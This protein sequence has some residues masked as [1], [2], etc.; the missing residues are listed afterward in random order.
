M[1]KAFDPEAQRKGLYIYP[2]FAD[3]VSF[4]VPQ[5]LNERHHTLRFQLTAV[6]T[7]QTT[8]GRKRNAKVISSNSPYHTALTHPLR[9]GGILLLLLFHII[10]RLLRNSTEQA[11]RH[12][13]FKGIR[14]DRIY[15]L[16]DEADKQ[17]KQLDHY[18]LQWIFKKDNFSDVDMAKF[19][20]GLPGYINSCLTESS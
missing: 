8:E 14:F 17:V 10:W 4:R 7:I 6:M 20:E 11:S 5:L 1:G 16:L 15:F 19:L 3:P 9:S 2:H 12:R 13:Y 18:A